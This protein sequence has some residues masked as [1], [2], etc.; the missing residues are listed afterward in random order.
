MPRN[1]QGAG[2]RSRIIVA[3]AVALILTS[4]ATAAEHAATITVNSVLMRPHRIGCI[5]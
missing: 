4:L 3:S 1:K 2:R 5:E